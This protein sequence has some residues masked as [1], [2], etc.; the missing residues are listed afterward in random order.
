[1]YSADSKT[2]QKGKENSENIANTFSK[3][4]KMSSS[5]FMFACFHLSAPWIGFQKS[6]YVLLDSFFIFKVQEFNSSRIS[7]K[8][9]LAK[10]L[11]NSNIKIKVLHCITHIRNFEFE[12][13]LIFKDRKN[14][15]IGR[16]KQSRLNHH[17]E[18]EG[19]ILL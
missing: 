13:G 16:F 17:L 19:L 3:N 11:A 12:D 6:F 10:C 14:F 2:T 7:S 18:G 8:E 1:M 4:F 5:I 15:F 9:S